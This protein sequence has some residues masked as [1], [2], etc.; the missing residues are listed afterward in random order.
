M[1]FITGKHMPR[2]TFLRGL[3]ATVALPFLDA[4]VP[5]R[6]LWSQTAQ[7]AALDRTRLVCIEMVHGAA[8]STEWGARQHLWAPADDRTRV[9]P[10]AELAQRR[11]SRSAST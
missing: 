2:R 4:M 1:A 5:A 8:G 6:A 7:A 9:R 3:G 10:V 11:S